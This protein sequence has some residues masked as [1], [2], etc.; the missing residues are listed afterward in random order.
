PAPRDHAHPL[1]MFEPELRLRRHCLPGR[2]RRA[3]RA[4]P[5]RAWRSLRARRHDGRAPREERAARAEL[6]FLL[7]VLAVGA[8]VA[9]ATLIGI[10]EVYRHTLSI[11][12]GGR[13]LFSPSCSCSAQQAL[14]E[15]GVRRGVWLPVKRLSRCHPYPPGGVDLV[16]PRGLIR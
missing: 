12:V 9:A 6:A 1:L 5:R 13:C 14:A 7:L 10:A 8:R 2:E 11:F 4:T 16:P 3:V 15:P